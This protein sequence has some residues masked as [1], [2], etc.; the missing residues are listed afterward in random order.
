MCVD[1][2]KLRPSIFHL[3]VMPHII[4]A[5]FTTDSAQFNTQIQEIDHILTH[6]QLDIADGVFVPTTTWADPHIISSITDYTFELHLMVA[7]PLPLI[8]DWEHVTTVTRMLV[9][10]ESSDPIMDILTTIGETGREKFIVLNPETSIDV[11]LPLIPHIDGVMCM[12]VPPGAQGQT[13]VPSVLEK[14]KMIKQRF[15][16]LYVS[17]DGGVSE[18]TLSEI[19][20]SG[21]DAL[22]VGSMIFG[23]PDTPVAQIHTLQNSLMKI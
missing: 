15:P 2:Q 23:R 5:L 3:S 14:I 6:L 4:P 17:I 20:S 12:G 9:H 1:L 7:H 16:H 22:C 13:L 18:N 19:V 11:L 8:H 21:V 10:I